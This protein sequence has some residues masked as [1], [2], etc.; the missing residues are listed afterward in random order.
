M[1]TSWQNR[2]VG[3]KGSMYMS[4]CYLKEKILKVWDSRFEPYLD[5]SKWLEYNGPNYVPD[6]AMVKDN[7]RRRKMW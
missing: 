5:P 7:K 1:I 4:L 2:G 3:Y 6:R